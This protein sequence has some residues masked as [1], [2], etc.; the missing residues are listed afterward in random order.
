M[1]NKNEENKTYFGFQKVDQQNKSERVKQVFDKVSDNYNL[2]NDLLSLG[3]HRL[4]K[5]VAAEIAGIRSDSY[6]LDLAGG[7]G[8]MVKLIAPKLNVKG[9]VILS[10]INLKMLMSGKDRLIDQGINNFKTVQIDAQVLPFKKN[11]FDIISMAFGLRNVSNKKK[12]LSS[13]IDCLKP[14]GKLVILEFSKP[15]NEILREIYDLYS[16]E[17]I[18]KLGN[19]VAQSEESYRYLAESIKMH[20]NQL[21]LKEL[22]EEAGYVDC[23]YKNL[24]NGIVAIHTG[25]KPTE[26]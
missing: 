12:T 9:E 14:G 21:E 3:V 8:D 5:R 17:V 22:F 15:K 1:D 4:W 25:K 6:V 16:F 13:I 18:P 20:P 26:T 19:L 7:T 11:T 24:T 2:M 23:N 10:D